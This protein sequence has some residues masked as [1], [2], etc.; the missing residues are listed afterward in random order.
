MVLLQLSQGDDVKSP[1]TYNFLLRTGIKMG[2]EWEEVISVGSRED[3][4][5]QRME[6]GKMP[7]IN[8][9]NWKGFISVGN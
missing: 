4:I 6:L 2:V 3:A 5:H 8:V 1:Q 9:G 7:F